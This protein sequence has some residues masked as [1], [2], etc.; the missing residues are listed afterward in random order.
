MSART[1][2]V[3]FAVL[4]FV[5][6]VV[7]KRCDA[8]DD[9]L[10]LIRHRHERIGQCR[11]LCVQQLATVPR[12][13]DCQRHPF[14]NSCWQLCPEF[15]WQKYFHETFCASDEPSCDKGCKTACDFFKE[16]DENGQ[17]NRE[18]KEFSTTAPEVALSTSFVGCTLYWK[19]SGPRDTVYLH[20]LYGLDEQVSML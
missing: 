5:F 20:Q 3:N 10:A 8:S 4:I 14:C 15:V 9:I 12:D 1:T 18:S 2:R 19:T 17:R 13:S 7:M 16:D 6:C 11:L